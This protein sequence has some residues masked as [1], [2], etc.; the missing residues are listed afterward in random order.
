[1]RNLNVLVTGAAGFLGQAL[2]TKLL[3]ADANITALILPTEAIPETW[4]DTVTAVR[5]DIRD[6][7]LLTEL[8]E[9][10]DCVFH[11]AALVGDWSSQDAH[12]E[13]T[14]GGT[15]N[16]FTAAAKKSVRVVLAS[17]IVVYGDNIRKGLCSE[18]TPH[19][20]PMG[21]YGWAKQEQENWFHFYEKRGLTGSII[22]PA[23]IYGPGSGPWLHDVV[24]QIKKGMPVLIDGG[25]FNAGL[26]YVENVA[27]VF[28]RAATASHVNGN[29]YNVVDDDEITW[30]HYFSDL[31]GLLGVSHL[32]SIPRSV[33]GP[34]AT[35]MDKVWRWAK[36]EQRPPVTPEA[37][38]LVGFPNYFSNEKAKH[39]LEWLPKIKYEQ[40][41]STIA[42]YLRKQGMISS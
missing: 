23:N 3:L 2:V 39:E 42:H 22:R 35:I 10:K 13:I 29:I 25:R 4:L 15:R 20:K 37:F 24:T 34:A 8:I 33:A 16:V 12:R 30:H 31:A 41:F 5:G 14:I 19:G 18:E 26:T 6:A 7:K 9:G 38:N 21:A 11:L 32:R 36:A 1:M 40:G 28:I 27:D 17:S